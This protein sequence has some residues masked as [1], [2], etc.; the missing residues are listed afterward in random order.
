MKSVDAMRQFIQSEIEKHKD[1]YGPDNMRDLVDLY[2]QAEKNDFKDT[3]G[4]NGTICFSIRSDAE[5]T[6]AHLSRGRSRIP[7]RKGAPTLQEGAPIYDFVKI[8]QKNA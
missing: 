6:H 3:K 2:I 1:T 5:L 4:M 7:R 8:F